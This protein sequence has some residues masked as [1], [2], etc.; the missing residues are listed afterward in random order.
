MQRAES[1][2]HD[3]LAAQRARVLVDHGAI[4]AEVL[5]EGDALVAES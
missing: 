1:L 2:R 3:A 4:A 5:V